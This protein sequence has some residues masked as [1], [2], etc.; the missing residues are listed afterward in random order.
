MV[1]GMAAYIVFKL[2]DGTRAAKEVR[3]EAALEQFILGQ[4][5]FDAEFIYL[6]QHDVIKRDAIIAARFHP[7]P[8]DTSREGGSPTDPAR[9]RAISAG[10]LDQEF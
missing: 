10:I 4:D 1:A 8:P 2:V 5:D 3:D 9:H 6:T 7:W